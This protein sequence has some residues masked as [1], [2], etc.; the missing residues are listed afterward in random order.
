VFV[1]TPVWKYSLAKVATDFID[2]APFAVSDD[3]STL[4]MSVCGNLPLFLLEVFS[5]IAFVS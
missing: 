1:E 5:L 4:A 2:L 3:G